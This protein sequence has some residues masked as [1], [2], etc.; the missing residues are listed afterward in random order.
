MEDVLNYLKK[1]KKRVIIIAA[2]V[3][4]LLI[5][6]I[7]FK[8]VVNYLSPSTKQSVYGDRCDGVKDI[9]VTKD[10]KAAIKAVVAS[11]PNME[12]KSIDVK[13]KLIDISINLKED[14]EDE[15]I[16]EMS[17]AI[18]ETLKDKKKNTSPEEYNE[19]LTSNAKKTDIYPN[20]DIELMIT[21][22]NKE[23]ATYPRIGTH[24]KLIVSEENG[25]LN[26]IINDSFVW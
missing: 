4:V 17:N 25:V 22:S 23:N 2:A 18:L 1:H 21:N 8:K 12:L 16:T 24:H 10:V 9:P 6:F 5:I 14:V 19:Y 11:Y 13:C 26:Y 7:A 20:Y 3:I 15:T